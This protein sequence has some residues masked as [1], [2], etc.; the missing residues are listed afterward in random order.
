VDLDPDDDLS[1]D[2]VVLAAQRIR[3][4]LELK[5]YTPFV[6]TSGGKGLH[7]Y[8]PL[9]AEATF[10]QVTRSIK[11]LTKL[12]VNQYPKEYTLQIAKTKRKGRILIDIYRNHLSNTTVAPFSL[13]GRPGAPVSM[14]LRWMDLDGLKSA[15][16][17]T[18]QNYRAYLDVYGDAWQNWRDHAVP[19]HDQIVSTLPTEIDVRLKSYDSKRD[20]SKTLEPQAGVDHKYKDHFV[21]QLHDA[22]NLHYDLRLEDKGILL[23]WAIPKGLPFQKGQKR[24]A[25]RTE[26]HPIKYL[27]FEGVIPQGEYGA[28]QMWIVESGI[29]TWHKK[30]D[31]SYSFTLSTRRGQIYHLHKTNRDDQWLVTTTADMS[32]YHIQHPEDDQVK[33]YSRSGRE[34]TEQ[35]PEL[36]LSEA[37][38]CEQAV[39]DGE[40]VVLDDKGRP[41]FHEVISRMHSKGAR[42]IQKGAE[43][44]PITCYLFDLITLDGNDIIDQSLRKRRSWLSTILSSGST[45]RMSDSF[46]DG[47][48]LFSA[49]DDQDME[50]IMA[51]DLRSKYTPGVRSTNWIKIKCRKTI[52]CWIIGYTIGQGDRASVFGALHLAERTGSRSFRYLGKVGTGFDYKKLKEIHE[53]L[54]DIPKSPKLIEE[55]IEEASRTIW[56]E[57][58]LSCEIEYA[59]LSS[60]GTLREPVFLRLKERQ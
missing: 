31:N 29:T 19:L 26:D 39:L 51:K 32:F 46:S 37:F 17:Y 35:F 50:G 30:T 55:S 60:N 27:D 14:P 40:L 53:M 8:V 3:S 33:I 59:T 57:A 9:I 10:D 38:K 22:S 54:K 34:I 11:S 52:D 1:F 43:T 13:R 41:R 36:Q 23:S 20:F 48:Q 21:I 16:Q 56:I 47:H 12:F 44:K 58:I 7:L 42:S 15:Q 28:G 4:F 45:Y 18:I 2:A 6:K 49:I 5:G 25:I 24:L